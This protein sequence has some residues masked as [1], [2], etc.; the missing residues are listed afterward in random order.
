MILPDHFL[1]IPKEF[2]LGNSRFEGMLKFPPNGEMPEGVHQDYDSRVA[3]TLKHLGLNQITTVMI[4]NE[5]EV[6]WPTTY[7]QICEYKTRHPDSTPWN[8]LFFATD[9][10]G[11]TVVVKLALNPETKDW[12]GL[13]REARALEVINANNQDANAPRLH[14]YYKGDE[15]K[16]LEALVTSAYL[17]SEWE[18]H[19]VSQYTE[20]SARAAGESIH[21][22]EG[23]ELGEFA[24]DPII[25][26][27]SQIETI[28]SV[29]EQNPDLPQPNQEF[30]EKMIESMYALLNIPDINELEIT[31]QLF[32]SLGTHD[33]KIIEPMIMPFVARFELLSKKVLVH[34]DTWLKNILLSIDNKAAFIDWERAQ[35]G[36]EG[37]DAGRTGWDFGWAKDELFP[38]Y[39]EAYIHAGGVRGDAVAQRKNILKFG[40]VFESLRWLHD[41]YEKLDKIRVFGKDSWM[42]E[43]IGREEEY[44]ELKDS[45]TFVEKK[46]LWMLSQIDEKTQGDS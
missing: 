45:I 12:G 24:G 21:S 35:K 3:N 40:I 13:E 19:H 33:L 29:A 38:A 43:K 1:T 34:G 15:D 42:A 32:T 30:M 25:S 36:Y 16:T 14:A 17:P 2:H 27:A 23:L 11:E 44:N 39:V 6:N 10:S 22:I 41:R 4:N 5:Q 26:I 20:K 8:S 31:E 7:Q 28:L 9:E 37:Q 46:A 18:A